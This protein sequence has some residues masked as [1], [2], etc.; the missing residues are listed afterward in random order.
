M[1]ETLRGFRLNFTRPLLNS[2]GEESDP[3]IDSAYSLKI[4]IDAAWPTFAS[5][6]LKLFPIILLVTYESLLAL[7]ILNIF[8]L[9]EPLTSSSGY[10]NSIIDPGGGTMIP[11]SV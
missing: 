6:A 2:I 11:L 3:D 9:A 7:K 1:L 8:Y 10:F 5:V 4:S